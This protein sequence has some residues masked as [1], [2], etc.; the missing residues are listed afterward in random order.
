MR[1][2]PHQ[3][4]II[5]TLGAS[6]VHSVRGS[7][8]IWDEQRP[9]VG[10]YSAWIEFESGTVATAAYSGYD[11]FQSAVLN[12]NAQT[13]DAREYARAGRAAAELGRRRGAETGPAVRRSFSSHRRGGA[14]SQFVRLARQRHDCGELRGWGSPHHAYG[15][16]CLRRGRT[17]AHRL[18]L[19]ETGR[20]E[21]VRQF[22]AAAAYGETPKHDARWS[23]ATLAVCLAVQRS[24]DENREVVV[25]L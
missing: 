9:V 7:V 8:G 24:A 18:P 2:G 23:K 15:A 3:L 22:Y 12:F 4:N 20:D 17:G 5:R 1:Q 25:D 6:R 13:E 21:I 16:R 19:D 11:R 10:M 14:A